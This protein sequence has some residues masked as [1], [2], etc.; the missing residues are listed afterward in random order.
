M[1]KKLYIIKQIFCLTSRS[2]PAQSQENN[3]TKVGCYFA[4]IELPLPEGW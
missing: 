2:K 1:K 3:R 4:D